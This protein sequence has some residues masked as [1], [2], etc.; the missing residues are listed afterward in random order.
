[1]DAGPLR[2]TIRISR[3]AARTIEYVSEISLDAFSSEVHISNFLNRPV[4]RKKEGIHFS[5]PFNL[6][7]GKVGY[8]CAWGTVELDVDRLPGANKNFI[9]ASRWVDVSE[10]NMGICCVL[11]DAPIFKSGP[12]TRDPWRWGP[13][14]L[15]G[16]LKHTSYNG[17][18]YS[19]V[20]NNYWQTNY[21]AD[22]PG[23]TLFRYV[24]KPHGGYSSVQNHRIALESAQPLI[25]VYGKGS[26]D[27]KI[28]M[29]SHEN[30]SMTLLDF[31]E[32]R[33]LM[34]LTNISDEE[35]ETTLV[36][37]ESEIPNSQIEIT[38]LGKNQNKTGNCITLATSETILVSINLD[39]VD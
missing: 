20:M 34:R 27:K 37:G 28:P 4:S 12:L 30:V 24:F 32:G 35:V 39:T 18:I 2:S 11:L 26:V 16:W 17:E 33:L 38:S 36:M 6:P 1:V 23:W 22:Q 9:T 29:P 5:Y 14:E 3:K 8:D 21:K 10:E 15:C 25:L 13:P 7:H 31:C 19:Y